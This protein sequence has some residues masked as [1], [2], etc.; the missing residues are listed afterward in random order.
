MSGFDAPMPTMAPLV[1]MDTM[2]ERDETDLERKARYLQ[3]EC[4]YNAN[5][6]K[7]W[8][9]GDLVMKDYDHFAYLMGNHVPL[10]STT[11]STLRS[12][13]K[14]VD[15]T[16]A[17]KSVRFQDTEDGKRVQTEK[18]LDLVCS[19]KGRMG[20]K[21]WRDI[22]NKDYDYFLWAVGNSMGRDTRT[23]NVFL[24]CLR[25]TDIKRVLE[26]E[27]GKVIVQKSI[28]KAAA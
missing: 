12:E 20:G 5:T 22:L 4:S 3:Y 13:L 6:H 11:Y 10:G 17:D 15:Q 16:M 8:T 24:Q 18:Y 25:E 27:K 21:T 23:F 19:H 14:I 26:T 28:K 2:S 1:R 9:W 7:G